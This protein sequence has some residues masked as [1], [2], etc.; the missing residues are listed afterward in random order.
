MA[1]LVAGLAVPSVGSAAFIPLS[2]GGTDDPTSIQATVD[3]FRAALGD[4]NN[5]N[6]PGPLAGGR[7]EINWDGG[8]ATTASP[9]GTPFNGFQ[10]TRG[11]QFTTPGSGFLQTPLDA[12]ELTGI[13]ATYQDEFSFFSPL[14]IFTP[15]GSNITD[16][17]F[18]LPGSGGATLATVDGFGAVFT[19]VELGTSSSMTFFDIDDNELFTANVPA[20]SGQGS[21]SFLGATATAGEQIFR[22]RLVSGNAALG[23]N[24]NPTG[25]IDVAA[26]DD[27]L[28]SE[29]QAVPEPAVLMLL[30]AELLGVYAFA[31]GRRRA[32]SADRRPM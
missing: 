7:R 26:L 4:P 6:A 19:D 9:A 14:R 8:G 22:V 1:C 15:V 20:G 28:Y 3:A 27:F 16:V 31:R 13:N 32:R 12:P 2:I 23:P 21:L 18:F 5:G 17:L 10:N 30:G 25:G 24:D 29:P 11:A